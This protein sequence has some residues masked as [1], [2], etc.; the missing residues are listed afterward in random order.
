MQEDRQLALAR[1]EESELKLTLQMSLADRG[2][3]MNEAH[4]RSSS[5]TSAAVPP[6]RIDWEALD[7]S[8][9][10]PSYN[11]R[12]K[13]GYGTSAT[14]DQQRVLLFKFKRHPKALREALAAAPELAA[15][16]SLL[17]PEGYETELPS[18]TKVLDGVERYEPL[19]ETIR[20][21]QWHLYP[22]HMFLNPELEEAASQDKGAAMGGHYLLFA[23]LELTPSRSQNQDTSSTVNL[24]H[25]R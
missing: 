22:K 18:G 23:Q 19:I 12:A 8:E 4:A 10:H 15:C 21:N 24:H 25:M 3:V 5:G 9:G 20:I 11:V 7:H 1:Y 13:M 2:Q 14:E 17:K 6:S 16:R